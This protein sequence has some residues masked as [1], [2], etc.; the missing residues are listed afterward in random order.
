MMRRRRFEQWVS[1]GLVTV[2]SLTPLTAQAEDRGYIDTHM[3]FQ[4]QRSGGKDLGK[5]RPNIAGYHEAA[6]NLV[7]QMNRY[8]VEKAIVMPP[9]QTMDKEGRYD[10]RTLLGAIDAHPGRLYLGAG[11]GTLNAMIH[12]V[13]PSEVTP[14]LRE[15]FEDTAE[16]L[17]RAG[18]VAFGETTAMHLCM[19]E[20]HNYSAQAPDH[21]LFLLLAD[22]AAHYGVPIDLHMEAV[23]EA[24]MTPQNLRDACSKNP[25]RLPATLPAFER[26]LAHNRNAKIVWQHI[27]WDNVG[28]MTS[29]L[30]SRLLSDHSNLYLAIRVE[31]RGIQ[32]GGGGPMPNRIVD[33]E[34]RIHPEWLALMEAHPDRFMVGGDE[35]IA[36]SAG[37]RRMPQSF[38]ETWSLLDQLPPALAQ[39]VGRDNAARI[40]PL[41]D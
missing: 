41:G 3:H 27:G 15:R 19:S 14:G 9:P 20:W 11:G 38:E 33:R 23:P 37:G 4:A 25:S 32:V 7:S 29:G 36:G 35:F 28:F 5:S 22:L 17:I 21:P 40:Y 6:R 2:L 24:M 30:V 12:S 34:G 13:E 16:E 10:Y 31:E 18:A 8:G 1:C 26:L 39:R